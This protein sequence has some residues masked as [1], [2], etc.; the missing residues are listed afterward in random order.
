MAPGDVHHTTPKKASIIG[1]VAYLKA[2]KLPCNRADVFRFNAVSKPRGW[3]ILREGLE[4]R[5]RRHPDFEMRGRKKLLSF[6]DLDT[7]ERII[8]Q[9][10]FKARALI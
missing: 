8:W 4:G 7:M 2:H 6:E 10:G 5:V 1:T 3:Q 9:F